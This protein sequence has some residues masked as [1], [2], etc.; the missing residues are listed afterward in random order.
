VPPDDELRIASAR[1]QEIADHVRLLGADADA[2]DAWLHPCGWTRREP[3]EH[4]KDHAPCAPIAELVNSFDDIWPAWRRIVAP[5]LSPTGESALDRLAARL[6]E[7]DADAYRDAID[8]L[9]GEQWADVRQ[10]AGGTL[11]LLEPT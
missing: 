9:D 1:L 4:T 10:L 11:P 2:Q 3:H 7:L 6:Q 8:T 5:V